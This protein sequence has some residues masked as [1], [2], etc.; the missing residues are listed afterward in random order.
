MTEKQRRKKRI[1]N[2]RTKTN[3]QAASPTQ[4]TFLSISNQCTLFNITT[5]AVNDVAYLYPMLP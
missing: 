4:P 5:T 2:T 1:N 3:L